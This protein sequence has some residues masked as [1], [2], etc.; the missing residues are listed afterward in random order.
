MSLRSALVSRLAKSAA[1]LRARVLRQAR[2]APAARPEDVLTRTGRLGILEDAVEYRQRVAFFYDNATDP[3]R[4]GRRVGAPHGVYK[5]NGQT[6]LLMWTAPGSASG[7]GRLP[8]W[9]TFLLNRVQN[10]QI[11]VSRGASG[12]REFP[13]APGYRRFRRGRFLFKA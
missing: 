2:P 4:S 7:S 12:L 13:I 6:Y 9:R 8:G 11:L 1:S 3:R 5:Y 10:P